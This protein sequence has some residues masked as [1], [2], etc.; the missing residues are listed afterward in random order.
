[1]R[2]RVISRRVSCG[3]QIDE[4]RHDFVAVYYR[5]GVGG[6]ARHRVGERAGVDQRHT[7]RLDLLRKVR[8]PEKGERATEL[9]GAE[10]EI[11][12]VAFHAVE[13]PVGEEYP[14]VFDVN[15]ALF[16][17]GVGVAVALDEIQVVKV[18]NL[19]QSAYPVSEEKDVIALPR[20]GNQ[21]LGERHAVCVGENENCRHK[22]TVIIA[23]DRRSF[24]ELTYCSN[25]YN[26]FIYKF[27]ENY[28][29]MCFVLCYYQLHR[30]D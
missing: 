23:L 8:V 11:E 2:E 21:P 6:H 13:V 27:N 29:A 26:S 17:G 28:I 15:H 25:L 7:V 3:L 22:S 30:C 16:G 20:H 9:L 24:Q 19:A 1:M 14:H 4:S 18:G 10:G 12:Q 5:V